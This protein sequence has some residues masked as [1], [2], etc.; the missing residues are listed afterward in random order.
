VSAT[1]VEAMVDA[2]DVSVLQRASTAKTSQ[3]VNTVSFDPTANVTVRK[4]LMNAMNRE[5]I[6]QTKFEGNAAV[7]HSPLPPWHQ[8]YD[9]EAAVTYPHDPDEAQSLLEEAGYGDGFSF[10]CE[11]TNQP[12]FVDVATILQQQY[13]EVG[14]DM[15]VEP[16]AKSATFEPVSSGPPPEDWHSLVEN[17]TWGYA[18]D[19]Y[20][21]ATFHSDAAFNWSHYSNEEADE[22]MDESRSVTASEEQQEIFS[23]IQQAITDDMPKLFL[24]WNNVIHGHRSRVNNLRVW[25]SAYMWFEDVWLEE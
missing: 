20:T 22:L 24:L 11:P 10:T 9:E 16:V 8:L 19:D 6:V 15:S 13:Q 2:A 5:A 18:A 12:K 1:E 14:V 23:E 25:A 21:W 7:A 3:W 4:A 17:F